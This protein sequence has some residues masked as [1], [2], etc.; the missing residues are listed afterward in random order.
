MKLAIFGASGRV[1]IQLVR[2]AL[3]AGNEVKEKYISQSTQGITNKVLSVSFW[4]RRM[5]E[6]S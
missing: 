5:I 2:Q 6:Y 1:G 3:E 4:P